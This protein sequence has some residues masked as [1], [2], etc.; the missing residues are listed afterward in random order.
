M[1]KKQIDKMSFDELRF[2]LA[3]G[4]KGDLYKHALESCRNIFIFG[5]PGTGKTLCVRY[6]LDQ[7]KS[8]AAEMRLDLGVVYVN[9]GRTRSPYYTM[10]EI[11][12]HPPYIRGRGV[13]EDCFKALT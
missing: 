4:L 6:A 3:M 2:A 13:F 1:N 10:L 11:Q 12:G 8:Y 7:L 9:A 5:K